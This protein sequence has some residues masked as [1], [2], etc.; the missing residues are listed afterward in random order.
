MDLNNF[1]YFRAG[2]YPGCMDIKKIGYHS[3]VGVMAVV[4]SLP[5]EINAPDFKKNFVQFRKHRNSPKVALFSFNYEV[6]LDE[7]WQNSDIIWDS[8]NP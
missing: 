1:D 6:E 2:E 5:P 3:S 4:S 8:R 7:Y